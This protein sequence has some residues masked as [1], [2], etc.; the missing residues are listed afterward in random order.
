VVDRG[1][2]FDN[3]MDVAGKRL[4]A[5][6]RAGIEGGELTL[7]KVG[8]NLT[9]VIKRKVGGPGSGRIYK[10]G[11]SRAHQASAPGAPPARDFGLYVNSWTWKLGVDRGRPYVDV[12]S[13]DE[14]GPWLEFGTSNMAPRPHLRPSVEE[15]T[16]EL[17]ETIVL[18]VVERQ[19][20]AIRS[21]VKSI[22]S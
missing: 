14:R 15:Y 22:V 8:V 21:L 4:S 10:R 2:V 7:P 12:G 20:E 18:G 5:V 1:E 19:R 16:G 6:V 13:N 3:V 9:N 11:L 17:R